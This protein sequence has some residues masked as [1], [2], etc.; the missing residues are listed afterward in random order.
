LSEAYPGKKVYVCN[1]YDKRTVMLDVNNDGSLS[2]LA[3]FA[4]KGEFS[5]ATDGSGNVYIADGDVYIF[6]KEGRQ[7][8]LIHIPE[9]PNSIT[10][11]GKDKKSLFVTG[12]EGLYIVR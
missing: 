10:F 12:R 2:N 6:D 11:G 5:T 1:E 8:G 4:E 7:K 3:R 9:R